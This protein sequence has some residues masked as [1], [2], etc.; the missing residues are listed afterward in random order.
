MSSLLLKVC[1]DCLP[2][3]FLAKLIAH[4]GEI[5]QC[6]FCGGQDVIVKPIADFL[7]IIGDALFFRYAPI[8]QD[9]ALWDLLRIGY[10]SLWVVLEFE[11][12]LASFNRLARD[13]SF[14]LIKHYGEFYPND[15]ERRTF[16]KFDCKYYVSE[17]LVESDWET[18]WKKFEDMIK[19]CVRHFNPEAYKLLDEIFS[20]ILSNEDCQRDGLVVDGGPKTNLQSLFRARQFFHDDHEILNALCRPDMALGPPP[21]DKASPGRMNARGIS[22]FYGATKKELA[23][24]EVR[25]YIDSC[26]IVAEVE[27]LRPIRLLNIPKLHEFLQRT[28]IF[29]TEYPREAARAKFIRNLESRISRPIMPH[30]QDL[31]YLPT[32]ALADFLAGKESYLQFD[33]LI[34]SS[35][36]LKDDGYNVVLFH[37]NSKNEE[38]IFPPNPKPTAIKNIGFASLSAHYS[39]TTPRPLPPS[40]IPDNFYHHFPYSKAIK[41]DGRE[42]TLRINPKTLTIHKIKPIKI[43]SDEYTIQHRYFEVDP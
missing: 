7:K 8:S 25:P 10:K 13:I 38:L 32:Q 41:K 4:D 9:T 19:T 30:D 36:I 1:R 2:E 3:Q 15:D 40:D 21:A 43:Q 11:L 17:A 12:K 34:Y 37:N 22:M 39:V 20:R 42:L 26:V 31:D 27:I 35:S 16:F 23:L 24:A 18:D 29:S 14:L 33:G 28:S 6:S 5:G